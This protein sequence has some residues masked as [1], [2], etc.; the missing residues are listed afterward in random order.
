MDSQSSKKRRMGLFSSVLS[1]VTV[2]GILILANL[3]A[4]RHQHSIDLTS[5]HQ[6]TLAPQTVQILGNLKEPV[7]AY[8]YY[9]EFDEGYDTA[10][11][12][13][14]LFNVASSSFTIRYVDPD[15]DPGLAKKFDISHYNTIVLEQGTRFRKV[16]ELTEHAITNTLI[17]LVQGDTRHTVYFSTGNGELDPES[18]ENDGLMLLKLALQDANYD[19][20]IVNLMAGDVEL[21]DCDVL[22]VIGPVHDPVDPVIDKIRSYLSQ[23][24]RLFVALEPGSCQKFAGLLTEFGISAADSIIVD[25]TGFQNMVQPI[26]EEYPAHEITKDFNSGLVFHIARSVTAAEP[27]MDGRLVQ[28]LAMT[29][30]ETYAKTDLKALENGTLEY[31]PDTD[32]AGPISVAVAYSE[33]GDAE[34]LTP[35]A[36]AGSADLKE[37]GS[38]GARIVA[39]GDADFIGNIFLQTFAT[40]QP[41]VMNAFHWLTDEEDLIA[42]PPREKTS[43]PLLLQPMQLVV[44]LVIPVILLPLSMAIFGIVRIITR[45]RRA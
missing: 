12:L 32:M 25:P 4:L 9:R 13:L 31:N 42:I 28:N 18:M 38:G 41:F 44:G 37:K 40:H 5:D 10:K 23:G 19:I 21:E 15:K 8:C 29:S 27:P 39:V 1:I 24:G 26:V 14:G 17:R 30:T 6:F 36:I 20:K 16:T 43:Q 45:R 2:V 3:I 33:I 22:A 35:D 34:N 11:D 7:V